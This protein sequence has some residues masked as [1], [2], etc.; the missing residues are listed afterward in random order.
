MK[1]PTPY[2][3][4]AAAIAVSVLSGFAA[5]GHTEDAMHWPMQNVHIVVGYPPGSAPD[6]LARLVV[7]PLSQTLG[8]PVVVENRS[9]A[10]GNLG[11]IA[12]LKSTDGHTFGFT[13]VGPLTTSK[14]LFKGLPYDP[15][16]DI[17]PIS[18]S[19]SSPLVLV[20]D[21]ELPPRSLK[22]FVAWAGTQADGVIY[23]SAGVGTGSNL[24]ME[25]FAS[26]TRFTV[27]HVPYSGIADVTT[28]IVGHQVQA[29][30]VPPSSAFALAAAGKLRMLA[31][32]S[33]QR[34]PRM[35]E[36]PTVAEES[37][38]ENFRSEVWIAAF[39][40]VAMPADTAARLGAEINNILKRPEIREKLGQQGWQVVGGGPDELRL[41][42]ADDAALWGRV[43]RDARVPAR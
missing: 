27:V 7:D 37:G 22:E 1:T 31:V 21:A 10:A 11:V 17:R 28:A 8:K 18:L 29:A 41:R 6:S 4:W 13:T 2:R 43:I 3:R 30:F 12:V 35:P 20:C 36:L 23:G 38:I 39:G 32:S 15:A 26:Q 9:G 19:A 25:L 14:L 33:A 24:T 16:R 5:V 40:P 42:M 34:L